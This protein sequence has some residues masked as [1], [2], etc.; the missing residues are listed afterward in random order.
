[1]KKLT[2]LCLCILSVINPN[3]AYADALPPVRAGMDA[4]SGLE[5]LRAADIPLDLGR[6]TEDFQTEN[7]ALPR[8]IL[9]QDAHSI[10]DAQ[11][12][13]SQ[14]TSFFQEKAGLRWVGLEGASGML[15]PLL[16]ASYP[17]QSILEEVLKSYLDAGEISGAVYAAV[18]G[19]QS[20]VFQGLENKELYQKGIS[21]YLEASV[22]KAE[23]KGRLEILRKR[24][25]QIRAQNYPPEILAAEIVREDFEK[26]KAEILEYL[27]ALEPLGILSEP[28][29]SKNY[30]LLKTLI[31]QA[32]E[33]PEIQERRLRAELRALASVL[34]R[35]IKNRDIRAEFFRAKQDYETEVQSPEQF[36]AYLADLQTRRVSKT[37]IPPLIRK[38]AGGSRLLQDAVGEDL[39]LELERLRRGFKEKYLAAGRLKRTESCGEMILLFEKLLAF[40]L[41]SENWKELEAIVR[42]PGSKEARPS[43]GGSEILIGELEEQ[44]D[45]WAEEYLKADQRWMVFYA[46]AHER[47]D[48]MWK[49]FRRQLKNYERKHQPLLLLTGGFHREGFAERLRRER[50]SYWVV[51][52]AI[53]SIP[54]DNPYDRHMRGDVSWKNRFKAHNGT[55][56]VYEA[57]HQDAF[58]RLRTAYQKRYGNEQ[59][60]I[61]LRRWRDNILKHLAE[62]R[63]L[64]AAPRYTAS[65]D[66]MAISPINPGADEN[67][68][69]AWKRRIERFIQS[70]SRLKKENRLTAES[71]GALFSPQAATGWNAVSPL[72]PRSR[73]PAGWLSAL[74]G[75]SSNAAPLQPTGVEIATQVVRS[76]L[77]ST[78]KKAWGLGPETPAN[79]QLNSRVMNQTEFDVAMGP[80]RKKTERL[81]ERLRGENSKDDS[82]PLF[83]ISHVLN[84]QK[85][86]LEMFDR[87]ELFI[88]QEIRG[89]DEAFLTAFFDETRTRLYLGEGFLADPEFAAETLFRL[90]ESRY[91]LP[92]AQEFLRE[93][94]GGIPADAGFAD[95]L[96]TDVA[97]FFR[98]RE[99]APGIDDTRSASDFFFGSEAAFLEKHKR[100]V[101]LEDPRFLKSAI[102]RF[103]GFSPGTRSE[104]AHKLFAL[105]IAAQE[106]LPDGS[107]RE[108]VQE[109]EEA[110]YLAAKL[111]EGERWPLLEG[112]DAN[113]QGEDVLSAEEKEKALFD[114]V[115]PLY[116]FGFYRRQ[117]FE[118]ASLIRRTYLDTIHEV[119]KDMAQA[120]RTSLAQNYVTRS[121]RTPSDTIKSSEIHIRVRRDG[122]ARA[123][124]AYLS[125]A[126]YQV[127]DAR[128][129]DNPEAPDW[130]I[131]E[132]EMIRIAHEVTRRIIGD[133]MRLLQ[134][135]YLYLDLNLP[136]RPNP[137]SYQ[138][139]QENVWSLVYDVLKMDPARTAPWFPE[140]EVEEH[141]RRGLLE[142]IVVM[143][144]PEANLQDLH[145]L[146]LLGQNSSRA[147]LMWIHDDISLTTAAIFLTAPS[148]PEGDRYRVQRI[149]GMPW[150]SFFADGSR[151]PVYFIGSGREG[152]ADNLTLLRDEGRISRALHY[153]AD[154]FLRVRRDA[155]ETEGVEFLNFH[156]L[157]TGVR[158]KLLA[159]SGNANDFN[160]GG[161][162]SASWFRSVNEWSELA[163]DRLM[164]LVRNI[165]PSF[166]SFY[167]KGTSEEE[168][169]KFWYYS[170]MRH[171]QGVFAELARKIQ[172][173]KGSDRRLTKEAAEA[174]LDAFYGIYFGGP[175]RKDFLDGNRWIL[176]NLMTFFDFHPTGLAVNNAQGLKEFLTKHLAES[177]A[178]LSRDDFQTWSDGFRAEEPPI[179]SFKEIESA[180]DYRSGGDESENPIVLQKNYPVP[181]PDQPRAYIR[182]DPR[183][184]PV[185]AQKIREE[186]A[187]N[188][189]LPEFVGYDP[190]P[191]DAVN[192]L[193]PIA[194]PWL[195]ESLRG[196]RDE[197]RTPSV[198]RTRAQTPSESSYGS[199]QPEGRAPDA[200]YQAVWTGTYRGG[201]T[202]PGSHFRYF[203]ESGVTDGDILE[204]R[205]GNFED[206]NAY[207]VEIW[208]G[209]ELLLSQG[210]EEARSEAF[211]QEPGVW[212][213]ILDPQRIEAA[214]Q[215][216]IFAEIPGA[217]GRVFSLKAG[218]L[219]PVMLS[220]EGSSEEKILQHREGD[221][222]RFFSLQGEDLGTLEKK[223]GSWRATGL[224][225][226]HENLPFPVKMTE[227]IEKSAYEK[228][229]AIAGR[230]K[231][232]MEKARKGV[233]AV[234]LDNPETLTSDGTLIFSEGELRDLPPDAIVQKVH[235]LLTQSDRLYEIRS[236][237]GSI[238]KRFAED[239]FYGGDALPDIPEIVEKDESWDDL[240]YKS[241]QDSRQ[242]L[243]QKLQWMNIL[244]NLD[245]QIMADKDIK[246]QLGSAAFRQAARAVLMRGSK[247]GFYFRSGSNVME[248][249]EEELLKATEGSALRLG[250]GSAT[251]NYFGF[252]SGAYDLVKSTGGAADP[253]F[254]I[255][256]KSNDGKA[257]VRVFNLETGEEADEAQQRQSKLRADL[258]QE[259]R[260]LLGL[261]E[262]DSESA[263]VDSER[264]KRALRAFLDRAES[265]GTEAA[266]TRIEWAGLLKSFLPTLVKSDDKRVNTALLM[267]VL[268]EAMAQ[269]PEFAKA[270][271]ESYKNIF[272]GNKAGDP[273]LAIELFFQEKVPIFFSESPAAV[274][275]D[276]FFDF[277]ENA[278]LPAAIAYTVET[279]YQQFEFVDAY[280]EGVLQKLEKTQKTIEKEIR[281]EQKNWPPE[282]DL[283]GARTLYERGV[284]FRGKVIQPWENYWITRV[285][286]AVEKEEQ[287][288]T[289]AEASHRAISITAYGG[290][291]GI[292]ASSAL[293]QYRDSAIIIDAGIKIGPESS[294]P[295]WPESFP[296]EP[297]AVFLTHAH[298]DHVGAAVDLWEKLGRR[299]PFYATQGT[300]DLL[301]KV[302]AF[303]RTESSESPQQKKKIA[304]FLKT[305]QVLEMG[306]WYAVSRDMKIYVH[307]PV[308][309]L[310]GA[311]S[312]A[313]STPDGMTWMSG[314]LSKK[315][316][317]PVRGFA[318]LPP[319]IAEWVDH[320][321]ME[322]TYG[323]KEREA[324]GD[325][326]KGLVTAVRNVLKK[327]GGRVLIPAFANGRA[328]RVL[329]LLL[330]NLE[331]IKNG[332]SDFKIYIDGQA[333]AFTKLYL[334]AYPEVF[335]SYGDFIKN[336]VVILD[337]QDH[338][339]KDL[340]REE[341]ANRAVGQ[342]T[343]V[344]ASA[345]NA[346]QGRSLEWAK[347]FASDSSAGIFF[348]G[349]MDPQ[350]IGSGLLRAAQ[351]GQTKFLFG[352]D[353]LVDLQASVEEFKLAGHASGSEILEI[354]QG[355]PNL[356][357]VSLV[358]GDHQSRRALM[359][360][361][362]DRYPQVTPELLMDTARS[363]VL[364]EK[365]SRVLGERKKYF[366]GL[367]A[368]ELPRA[369]ST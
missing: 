299:V 121:G 127:Y 271:L 148:N 170:I 284:S 22:L 236:V 47:E 227:G 176:L 33:K 212:R 159:R 217:R 233:D 334:E 352:D 109:L 137:E 326:E 198:R 260:E 71:L 160:F 275:E 83:L 235:D 285:F 111:R 146:F 36:A 240:D 368:A 355:M 120:M 277:V 183:W 206:P 214:L 256:F 342:K 322:S 278:F 306:Q 348:T 359:K 99:K 53:A 177:A 23:A 88:F 100:F 215:S 173:E 286:E 302:L 68:E 205:V 61:F 195:A 329:L 251:V 248:K 93:I 91:P 143:G 151:F 6:V 360:E 200:D 266:T 237:L 79:I 294:P 21:A 110:A 106:A 204:V 367:Q 114:I 44:A 5:V 340:L 103:R 59:G 270:R 16:L 178:V 331:S 181:A 67:V 75:G 35:E 55:I 116:L 186:G 190:E 191:F 350:E 45:Q 20:T 101:R 118:H 254:F 313:I 66:R 199:G 95:A 221:G 174:V 276:K 361:I 162:D 185:R 339:K 218:D 135:W 253:Y 230:I 25:T 86:L 365:L 72:E 14:L 301:E 327:E 136:Q 263:T 42:S 188:P 296:V 150:S 257:Q 27:R 133:G 168:K 166:T 202:L 4:A 102:R 250:V 316:Q 74:P 38:A 324:E 138:A 43:A 357:R 228:L 172:Y 319:E 245:R 197:G 310:H 358:H 261:F 49:S 189:A 104:S 241:Y 354:L 272:S 362:R 356:R 156:I 81:I 40:E 107:L 244:R 85:Y 279:G 142:P 30:P 112:N 10:A 96:A 145:E 321:V 344:I 363:A 312:L 304:D 341:I 264:V 80:I 167:V 184:Q 307:G 28:Q 315:S 18:T 323:M 105:W 97:D 77:R 335:G 207:K 3:S 62:A 165:Y 246:K 192:L 247:P 291:D 82:E 139:L 90:A 108:G 124:V 297:Q 122:L 229:T 343:I 65:L 17:D 258:E 147:A 269:G 7:H 57:F 169:R 15:D 154:P 220:I 216:G 328:Q 1:M 282:L 311:A 130:A 288:L 292:G 158:K 305:L 314:D 249:Y 290:A 84:L 242:S 171:P 128:A 208:K 325:Q 31:E 113:G 330:E 369:P 289:E 303:M 149:L 13:I 63:R 8:V 225:R 161:L 252:N 41:H 117:F 298:L 179:T 32:G 70:V 287:K 193:R 60:S 239:Q 163:D 94:T 262:K 11:R 87:N 351:K 238:E 115:L 2:A 89:G 332:A 194:W 224:V 346:S 274:S 259:E 347:M 209:D 76:E 19:R 155:Y 141:Y 309:H 134:P 131:K 24:F 46:A 226:L 293:V 338:R 34:E 182:P 317:G 320:A 92:T 144:H 153:V 73:F 349:Y 333:A 234:V 213:K 187:N 210:I 223:N 125:E 29:S 98:D 337:G 123:S 211:S 232:M 336:Y 273:A 175:E 39:R 64:D 140:G 9:L 281:D 231:P 203:F 119:A 265:K 180:E 52:P 54:E 152:S 268:G 26:G 164:E 295:N 243:Q 366:E 157:V 56:S 219:S 353:F 196:A 300:A 345:G 129:R 201:L 48:A 37:Q 283:K 50:I 308:G 78:P 132:D 364:T 58:E 267:L 318:A 51:S 280:V 255:R 69:S 222:L 12:S 126:L